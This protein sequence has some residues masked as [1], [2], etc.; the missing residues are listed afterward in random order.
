VI[1]PRIVDIELTNACN[2]R[3][4]FCLRATMRR[5]TGSMS[6]TLFK[7][8]VDE[9]TTFDFP[10]W[11]KVVLAGFGEPTLH[12]QF[13]EAVEYAGDRHLPLRVYTNGTGL[14]NVVCR[15]LMH[16]GIQSLKLS[17]NVHGPDM[18]ARVIGKAAS[19]ETLVQRIRT[20][21][22]ARARSEGGPEITIQ[23]LYTG[24][25]L[26]QV[27]EREPA[28]LDTPAAAL[29]AVRFWQTQARAIAEETGTVPR[30]SPVT[31]ADVRPGQTFGLLENVDLK[32]CPYLP[33]RTHFDSA[34]DWPS[35]LNFDNCTRHFNNVVI[36]HEGSCT[37]CCTDVNCEMYL[38]NVATSSVM[39]IFNAPP[40]RHNRARWRAGQPVGELCR[41]CLAGNEVS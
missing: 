28:L 7:K 6:L 36:F 34:R 33:Y 32:L 8:I 11:G 29:E 18:L 19:W 15:R 41:I 10:R 14:N 24:D 5:P 39:E 30:V 27:R 26:P 23:L 17:L 13:V 2:Q 3:C 38:G 21:L 16:P 40:A 35:G 9:L 25:L 1:Q 4:G 22:R 31:Q 37:P 20:L 12:P